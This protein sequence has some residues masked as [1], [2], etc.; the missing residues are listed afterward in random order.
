MTGWT[1]VPVRAIVLAGAAAALALLGRDAL[2]RALTPSIDD[3]AAALAEVTSAL[4]KPGKTLTLPLHA[5]VVE[6]LTLGAPELS[7]EVAQA[8]PQPF[9]KPSAKREAPR[10]AAKTAPTPVTVVTRAEVEA[11]IANR[12]GGARTKL[13]RDEDGAVVG[14]AVFGAGPLA[15]FGV[16]DGDIL[17]SANGYSLRTPSDA[18]AALGALRDA[19]KITVVFRRGDARYALSA[20]IAPAP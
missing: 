18:L 10:V 16:V 7:R 9:A 15:R 3:G 1:R 13:V 11:A 8:K 19:T 5:P 12:L 4:P 2:F 14:L 20:D 6:E 17:V